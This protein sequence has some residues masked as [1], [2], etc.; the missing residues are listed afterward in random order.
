M[1]TEKGT[2][3][4][5][6]EYKKTP[7]TVANFIGLSEGSIKN[8]EKKQGEPFYDGLKFHR[9]YKDKMIVGGCPK[10][11]GTGNPG[12]LF[13]DEFHPDLDPSGA[14]KLC[15][16][17]YGPITNGSQFILTLSDNYELKEKNPVFG[18]VVLG[19]DVLKSIQ[20][21]D[22]IISIK[23]IRL[24]RK[25]QNF[26]VEKVFKDNGFDGLKFEKE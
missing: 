12:Y 24:G 9:V 22:Q 8:S 14:G 25:A 23:I 5:K 4:A 13:K 16:Q 26:N 3:I 15:M 2:I 21:G 18:S 17:N 10:G 1:L 11:D 7:I 6:L 20:Q 19:M